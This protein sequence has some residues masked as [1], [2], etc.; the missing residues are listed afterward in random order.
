MTILTDI[1]DGTSN[2]LFVSECINVSVGG[3]QVLMG[4]GRIAFGRRR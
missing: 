1:K 4:D 3:V 2:T